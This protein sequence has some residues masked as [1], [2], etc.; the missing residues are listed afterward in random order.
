MK[1]NALLIILI[2]LYHNTYSEIKLTPQEKL[3]L[4]KEMR[5]KAQYK[6]D[7]GIFLIEAGGAAFSISVVGTL[8][9]TKTSY[10]S[11]LYPSAFLMIGGLV[12]MIWGGGKY[13]NGKRIEWRISDY[14][15]SK[16]QQD[17]EYKWEK[18][19]KTK[20]NSTSV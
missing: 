10:Q 16:K 3:K 11:L 5:I 8:I 17:D 19:S 6:K 15:E 7:D 18:E 20:Q 4:Q 12:T 13:M 14:N 9:T 1:K 2:G